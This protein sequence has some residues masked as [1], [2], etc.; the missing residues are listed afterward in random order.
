MVGDRRALPLALVLARSA[1]GIGN[2]IAHL[3]E[4]LGD[5]TYEIARPQD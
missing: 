5:Q 2:Q 3:R 1:A 4:V